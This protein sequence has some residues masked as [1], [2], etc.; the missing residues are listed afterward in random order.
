MYLKKKASTLID[1]MNELMLLGGRVGG[2]ID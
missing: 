1:L 2:R